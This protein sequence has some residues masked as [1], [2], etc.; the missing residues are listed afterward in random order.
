[1]VNKIQADCPECGRGRTRVV[2]TN[3]DEEGIRIRRR[4]CPACEHRW[5]SIQ[6]PE[7]IVKNK[8]IRWA[9]TGSTVRPYIFDKTI[10][11]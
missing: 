10:S 8:E 1:M 3:C 7:V 4:R 2:C 5:Y 9:K 11:S 6:Y